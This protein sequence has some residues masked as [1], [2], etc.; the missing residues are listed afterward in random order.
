MN[1]AELKFENPLKLDKCQAKVGKK[2]IGQLYV[3]MCRCQIQHEELLE[4]GLNVPL[5]TRAGQMDNMCM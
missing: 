2:Q 4:S 5:Y 3:E 1:I